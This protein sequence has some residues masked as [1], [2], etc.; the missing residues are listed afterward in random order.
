[1]VIVSTKSANSKDSSLSFDNP[2]TASNALEA[3]FPSEQLHSLAELESWRKEVNR[4]VYHVHKWWANRLGSIFRAIALAGNLPAAAD[5]WGE[6]YR[7]HDFSSCVVLDPFM[8]SGTT[9][10]EALKLGCKAVGC[11]INPVAYFQVRKALDG[12]DEATLR[13]G[14]ER[15]AVNVAPRIREFYSSTYEGQSADLLYT[16]WVKVLDC[17]ACKKPTRLFGKWIFSANAYPKKKPDSWC[18][19]PKCG[20]IQQVNHFTEHASCCVCKHHFN[21]QEGPAEGQHFWCE[22]CGK[23]HKI[24]DVIR[25][26]STPARHEMYALML[27]LPNGT[28]VYKKPDAE[29]LALYAR[30]EA[31]L[32]E[33]DLPLPTEELKPGYNTNQARGYNYLRWRDMFN[34][35]Q[36]LALGML[37]QEILSEPDRSVREYLLLLFSNTLEFNNMFCSFKGEGTGAVR[38]LFHHHILKPERTPLEA[39]PWGTDKSS[40]AFSTLFERKLMAAKRYCADPF[41]LRVTSNDGKVTGEKVFGTNKPLTPRLASCFD[42]LATGRADALV[43][44]GDSSRLPLPSESVDLVIT[45]P[46]YFDNVHYSE[47]ADFF[48]CWLRLGLKEYDPAFQR[49]TTRH[50]Q[51]VQQKDESAFSRLL[52]G[53]FAECQRVL[54]PDGTLAFTFHHSREEAWVAVASAIRAAGLQVVAAHPVKAEMSVAI[55]KAQAKEPINLDLIVVCKKQGTYDAAPSLD[56]LLTEAEGVVERYNQIGIEL[57]RGDVRVILMGGFLRLA[58]ATLTHRQQLATA[59]EEL[60]LGQK[61]PA[62]GTINRAAQLTIGL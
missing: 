24:V 33:S 4:P 12:W 62:P 43:I 29:D 46:P 45:D 50:E 49:E 17:S 28:K 32:A 3:G 54:K 58:E 8:G 40:G 27:L 7:S 22:H 35:R 19:C 21:P 44:S 2:P 48:Y 52:G 47:L 9:V 26:S 60:Y 1:M 30:A 5:V 39:N 16:F 10:G 53:V 38:H 56:Q 51:E 31:L 61:L 23:D 6:F 14:F 37:L 13:A 18:L 59:I 42:D 20:E 36:L 11:D 57:S 41:E 15:L 34:S 25:A 55:P